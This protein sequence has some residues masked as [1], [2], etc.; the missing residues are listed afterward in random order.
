MTE[1]DAFEQ[2]Y[3]NGYE[4]GKKAGAPK[5]IS[6]EERKPDEEYAAAL[7]KGFDD[8]EVIAMIEN[9]EES[10]ALRYDGVVGVFFA[11]EAGDDGGELVIYRVTHW[12]PMPNPPKK[13]VQA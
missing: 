3:R 9:A 5:W 4:A 7:A 6:V 13:E 11:V 8:V 1:H 2:A 12:M 10:T